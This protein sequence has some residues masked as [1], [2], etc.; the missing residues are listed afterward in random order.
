M[1]EDAED[2]ASNSDSVASDT[3]DPGSPILSRNVAVEGSMNEE[4]VFAGL[5]EIL[6]SGDFFH[7]IGPENRVID[8]VE[9]VIVTDDTRKTKLPILPRLHGVKCSGA[10]GTESPNQKACLDL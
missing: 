4:S 3:G 2:E 1:I 7:G 9:K 10:L 5:A 8:C 6:R